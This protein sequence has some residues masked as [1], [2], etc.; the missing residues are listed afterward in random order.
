MTNENIS[1]SKTLNSRLLT[2]TISFNNK[3]QLYHYNKL[4]TVFLRVMVRLRRMLILIKKTIYLL[5]KE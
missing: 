3:T 4:K 5:V 1:Q 2:T